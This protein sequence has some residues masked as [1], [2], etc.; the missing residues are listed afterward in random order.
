MPEALKYLIDAGAAAALFLAL[1]LV[2]VVDWAFFSKS[3]PGKDTLTVKVSGGEK[4][5]QK[6]LKLAVT[7]TGNPPLFPP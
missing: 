4:G 5:V 7:P 3:G 6:K 1:L 2:F